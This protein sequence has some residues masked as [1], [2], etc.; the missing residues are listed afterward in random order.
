M[1]RV[2]V[3]GADGG[4]G[5]ETVRLLTSDSHSVTGLVLEPRSPS[6]PPSLADRT[7]VG[8][9]TDPQVVADAIEGA[10]AVVHLAAIPHPTLGTPFEVYRTNV[11]ATFAVLC[12]AGERGVPR[13]V[14]ASSIN[15]LGRTLNPHRPPPPWFPLD[16]TQPPDAADAYSLSKRS[17]E[18][19]AQ[20]AARRWG[21]TVVSLRFP[22]VATGDRLRDVL[23]RVRADPSAQAAEGWAYLDGRDAAR[24]IEAAL[25]APLTGAHVVGLSARDTLLDSP[26][27]DALAT[28]LPDVPLRRPIPGNATAIDTSRAQALLGFRPRYSIHDERSTP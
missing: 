21:M 26:T 27:A 10:D 6:A 24:A 9:C 28:Y 3:T 5:R 7:V 8:D 11:L 14:V 19:A 17:G 12:V 20:M 23:A 18:D 22:F 1:T 2:L 4:I 25:T 15:A 13:V 16:E